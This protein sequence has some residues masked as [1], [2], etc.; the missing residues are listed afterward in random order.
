MGIIYLRR[1]YLRMDASLG[2]QTFSP[3]YA[4]ILGL[5]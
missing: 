4:H 3:W 5:P 2:F 1:D